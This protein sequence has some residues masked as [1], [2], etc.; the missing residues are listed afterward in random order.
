MSERLAE[1]QQAFFSAM[2][3]GRSD[4]VIAR[5]NT[6]R[7]IPANTGMSIY[8]HAYSARLY[9]AIENDHPVLGAYLGDALWA[10]LCE[11]YV[12]AYP[13]RVRSLRH[14]G[15]RLPDYLRVT[16]PFSA[17]GQIAEIAQWERRL[18]DCFDAAD[19]ARAQW[20][21]LLV[22]PGEAWPI[23]QLR[24]HP[25]VQWLRMEWNSIEIWQALKEEHTPPSAADEQTHWLLWRDEDRVTQF[26]SMDSDETFALR[27]F[28]QG[29][30]FAE[31]CEKLM[32]LLAAESIPQRLIELL[33]LWCESGL[34]QAWQIEKRADR[35]DTA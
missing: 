6:A 28:L 3:S 34:I 5:L 21:T 32:E 29:N 19:T 8:Q 30:T 35:A 26:R 24:F 7:G 10:T 11:G 13:S 18:L 22:M 1:L 4:R 27:C 12:S 17:S 31:T 20:D 33:R 25:S 2:Q 14:F 16:P 23:L 9:E 15:D